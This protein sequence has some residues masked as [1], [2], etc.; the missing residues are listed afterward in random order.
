MNKGTATSSCSKTSPFLSLWPRGAGW[1]V[2][3]I[4]GSFLPVLGSSC[5]LAS[6]AGSSGLLG[7]LPGHST[8]GRLCGGANQ[9]IQPPWCEPV[10]CSAGARETPRTWSGTHPWAQD[11]QL[12]EVLVW[13]M[14]PWAHTD[15]PWLLLPRRL[16]PPFQT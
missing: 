3:L 14:S 1:G 6:R 16:H 11:Q 12:T 9:P 4:A 10:Q 15:V 8:P 5:G 2:M 13:A 7:L